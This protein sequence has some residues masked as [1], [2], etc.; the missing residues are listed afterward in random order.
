MK[1]KFNLKKTFWTMNVLSQIK[2]QKKADILRRDIFQQSPRF[3]PCVVLLSFLK[4]HLNLNQ[5][6]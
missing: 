5:N 1:K 2:F 6:N 3:S 4:Q